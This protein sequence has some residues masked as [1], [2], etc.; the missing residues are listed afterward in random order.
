MILSVWFT[1]PCLGCLGIYDILSQD[2]LILPIQFPLLRDR[3]SPG[4]RTASVGAI[5]AIF[6][7][8]FW[9]G[10]RVHRLVV[11]RG[12]SLIMLYIGRLVAGPC[13]LLCG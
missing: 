3:F 11:H 5:A 8:L 4:W 10:T 2:L 12:V 6:V 13:S 1:N 9:C 7:P